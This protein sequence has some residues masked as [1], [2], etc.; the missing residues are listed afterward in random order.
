MMTGYITDL[1]G[2]QTIAAVDDRAV[3]GGTDAPLAARDSRHDAS[4][5]F[6]GT[7][8]PAAKTPAAKRSASEV[9]HDMAILAAIILAA[10]ILLPHL[11]NFAGIG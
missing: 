2:R 6:A 3:E 11:L 5:G 4:S 10:L 9:C 8:N 1:R 7:I